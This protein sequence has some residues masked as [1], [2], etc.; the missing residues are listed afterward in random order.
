MR[1]LYAQDATARVGR[2]QRRVGPHRYHRALRLALAL[3]LSNDTP[4]R[5]EVDLDVPARRIPIDPAL[6]DLLLE[7]PLAVCVL[8]RARLH[9]TVAR[10]PQERANRRLRHPTRDEAERCNLARPTARRVR[11]HYDGK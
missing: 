7:L 5:V 4:A 1:Q 8:V 11:E 9:V 2:L 10:R 3:V 6:L